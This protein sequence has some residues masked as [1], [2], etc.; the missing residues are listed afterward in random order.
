MWVCIAVF[1]VLPFCLIP[2]FRN[3]T[4]SAEGTFVRTVLVALVEGGLVVILVGLLIVTMPA[5]PRFAS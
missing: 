2:T 5:V 3:K 4:I 1:A